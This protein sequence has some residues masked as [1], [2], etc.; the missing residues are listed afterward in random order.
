MRTLRDR[1]YRMLCFAREYFECRIPK[2]VPELDRTAAEALAKEISQNGVKVIRDRKKLL[3][4]E[5]WGKRIAH[6][7]LCN[8]WCKGFSQVEGLTGML[9][10]R[11]ASVDE[12]RDPGPEKLEA[13][14]KSGEYD[15]IVCS[16]LEGPSWG[17]NSARLNGPV[18]RNMMKGWMRLRTPAV[19]VAWQSVCFE[20]VFVVTT[21]TVINTYG[22]TQYTP[23]AVAE[24]IGGK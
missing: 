13:I 19:F 3:P 8:A 24:L 16:V 14:A 4:M 1:A 11:A 2:E 18:A 7:I 5:L 15:L 22:Y 20:D 23:T 21:D 10:Q 9:R 6:V 17:L 12:L